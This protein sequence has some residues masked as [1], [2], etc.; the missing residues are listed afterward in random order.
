MTSSWLNQCQVP[1][2]DIQ[3]LLLANFYWSYSLSTLRYVWYALKLPN[4][5]ILH[6]KKS[7]TNRRY[8]PFSWSLD[9]SFRKSTKRIGRPQVAALWYIG[10]KM[11][12]LTLILSKLDKLVA[13]TEVTLHSMLRNAFDVQMFQFPQQAIVINRVLKHLIKS[14]F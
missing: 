7:S 10:G 6:K 8:F 9:V 11:V 2:M 14:C 1:K 4:H 13:I 5:F 3:G 12:Q